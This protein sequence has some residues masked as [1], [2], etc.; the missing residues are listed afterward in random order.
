MEQPQTSESAFPPRPRILFFVAE[1]SAW[2]V[3]RYAVRP[4]PGCTERTSLISSTSSSRPATSPCRSAEIVGPSSST[5]RP[6]RVG[7]PT[8]LSSRLPRLQREPLA[9]WP[10]S[11]SS[12]ERGRGPGSTANSSRVAPAASSMS[13][14]A[15]AAISTS[16]VDSSTWNA[17]GPYSSRRSRPRVERGGY[18]VLARH[19]RECRPHR[20]Y[21]T[22]RHR[23]N[24]SR[25]RA[26][27][28]STI[29]CS[30][31]PDDLLRPG[32]TCHRPVADGHV[33]GEQDFLGATGVAITS[34]G[35]CRSHRSLG[36]A[37]LLGAR[38]LVRRSGPVRRRIFRR[39]SRC[40]TPSFDAGGV[41]AMRNGKTPAYGALLSSP[42]SPFEIGRLAVRPGWHRQLSSTERA[43]CN[44]F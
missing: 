35:T 11:W 27:C 23:L 43:L 21:R 22:I 44:R 34:Q 28:F 30:S 40:R 5:P 7:A 3:A 18:D 20:S 2:S 15:T 36:L 10:G 13:A 42:P 32:G 26:R 14:P 41:P 17:L 29:R 39:R 8:V 9:A 25:P 6:L 4:R 24:E 31:V 33:L 37:G 19:A 12:S 1:G 16:S 38:W